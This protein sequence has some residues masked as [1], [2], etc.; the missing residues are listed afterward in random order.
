MFSVGVLVTGEGGERWLCLARAGAQVQ[1][2]GAV[3]CSGEG[4]GAHVVL[5]LFCCSFMPDLL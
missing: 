3:S 4:H 1:L 5:C 2:L